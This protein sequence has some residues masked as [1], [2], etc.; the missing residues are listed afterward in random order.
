MTR[1]KNLLVPGMKCGFAAMLVACVGT[2]TAVAQDH[3]DDYEWEPGHGVHE[4]EWYDPSDW[5][6]YET[7][8]VDYEETGDDNWW[9]DNDRDEWDENERGDRDRGDRDRNWGD[10]DNDDRDRA[11]RNNRDRD[12][13]GYGSDRDNAQ[14]D[15]QSETGYEYYDQFYSGYYNGYVDG[16]D[17]DSFGYDE[18]TE[19]VID[20]DA[21]AEG[22]SAGYYDGYYDQSNDY[23]SDPYYYVYIE[24][25]TDRDRED[26]RSD[27]E[28]SGDRQ[29]E[30][31]DRSMAM[32]E[33]GSESDNNMYGNRGTD[34][35]QRRASSGDRESASR[36]MKQAYAEHQ[37]SSKVRGK[38]ADINYMEGTKESDNSAMIARLTME[39][40]KKQV[41]NLG[42]KMTK[43]DLPFEAGDRVTLKGDTVQKDGRE[44]LRVHTIT[45]GAEV[46]RIASRG[47]A[48]ASGSR[49]GMDR[50]N[51]RANRSGMA[52]ISGE[53]KRVN[54]VN[55]GN[56][57]Y[58]MYRLSMENGQSHMV[59]VKEK[60]G[61]DRRS[62][63]NLD[64]KIDSGDNVTIRG[65]R[66]RMNGE[67]VLVCQ[68]VRVNG[69]RLQLAS[70]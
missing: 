51:D 67:T 8:G 66:K 50:N 15:R 2:T 65:E 38:V 31:G 19:K 32:T 47:Y 33:T 52:S 10:R 7:T 55:R 30:R 39:D 20:D 57:E 29:R 24:G 48:D 40:G 42:P 25:V 68:S 58:R 61:D 26:T 63:N 59:A 11:D 22:Y 13:R 54:R 18:S 36:A 21:Y 28:R 70:R 14:T 12:R 1:K 5:F 44:M 43:D 45:A 9:D 35:D 53:I 46:A 62:H 17:D 4:Q 34:R 23:Q 6:D 64:S 41:V 60:D 37:K 16:F 27:R 56:D 69:E 3:A 49:D